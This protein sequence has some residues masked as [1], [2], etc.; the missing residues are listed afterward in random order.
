MRRTLLIVALMCSVA[1]AGVAVAGAVAQ[2]SEP[3]AAQATE[4][5]D[6]DCEYPLEVT[7]ATGETI[8]LEEQPD[9]IVATSQS[10]AQIAWELDAEERVTG[11]PVGPF[12]AYLD[13]H[14]EKTDITDAE[15]FLDVERVVDLSPD[16]V[17]APNATSVESVEQLRNAGLT[18]Y[19][20]AEAT[21][22]D[23]VYHKTET[24]GALIG[25]CDAAE[26]T[27]D[28]MN[29]RIE[30]VESTV[31]A[32]DQPSAFYWLS[33]GFTAGEGTFQHELIETAGGQNV[34]ADMGLTGWEVANDEEIVDRNPERLVINDY[35][36]VPDNEAIQSTH[37]VQNDHVIRVDGN[38]FS[39]PAPR[40]AIAL[41]ELAQGFHPEAFEETAET[42]DPDDDTTTV[43]DEEDD[44]AAA[45][46]ATDDAADE[47]DPD[48]TTVDGDDDDAEPVNM[49]A[50]DGDDDDDDE[51]PGFGVGA[52]LVALLGAGVALGRRR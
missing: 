22:I 28:W 34:A 8:T 1:V 33:G 9:E 52:A 12:S 2:P 14:D 32:D 29:D 46:D 17:I 16:I 48:D 6:L 10:A 50:A 26:E 35:A 21:S 51:I 31:P 45:D 19:H 23:D 25:E 5:T 39:Q 37:A 44:E 27:T 15:G 3:P 24:S 40:I 41:E 47:G 18:V 7:D 11:M 4:T 38:Y 43:D 36:E 13:G 30:N 42:D 20:F 49:T